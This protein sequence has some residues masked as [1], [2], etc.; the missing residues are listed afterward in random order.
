MKKMTLTFTHEKDTKNAIRYQEEVAE[1]KPS[2][3]GTLYMQKWAAEGA[4]KIKVTIE[5]VK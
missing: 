5:E 1:G 3:I 2:A 4:T